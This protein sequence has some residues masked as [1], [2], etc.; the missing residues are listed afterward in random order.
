MRCEVRLLTAWL[1][2]APRARSGRSGWASSPALRPACACDRAGTS[3][4]GAPRCSY[5]ATPAIPHRGTPARCPHAPA[6]WL[7]SPAGR[8]SPPP[9]RLPRTCRPPRHRGCL[10]L[11]VRPTCTSGGGHSIR[12]AGAS[13][14]ASRGRGDPARGPGRGV[15]DA[16]SCGHRGAP[17]RD[18]LLG[19]GRGSLGAQRAGASKRRAAAHPP[20]KGN[21]HGGGKQNITWPPAAPAKQRF[22]AVTKGTRPRTRLGKRNLPEVEHRRSPSHLQHRQHESLTQ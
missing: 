18:A 4:G 21:L 12:Q 6:Q 16:A 7:L 11:W 20:G 3:R 22:D 1:S 10:A 19:R 8:I 9:S 5:E 13:G 17:A 14:H 15:G 2:F